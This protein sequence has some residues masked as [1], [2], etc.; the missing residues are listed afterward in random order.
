MLP[1]LE[2]R[3]PEIVGRAPQGVSPHRTSWPSSFTLPAVKQQQIG[4]LTINHFTFIEVGH[5]LPM[6]SHPEGEAHLTFVTSGR[7][8]IFGE[9][10][11]RIVSPGDQLQFDPEF[12]HAYE[13]LEPMSRIT[14][15]IY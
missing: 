14:N 6:H 7:L 5:T 12:S 1:K 15:I 13:A 8:R 3:Y 11:E 9:G 2:E 10:W 4:K